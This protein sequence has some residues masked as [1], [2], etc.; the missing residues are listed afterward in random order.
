MANVPMT[1]IRLQMFKTTCA[2]LT[3]PNHRVCLQECI[4]EI[5]RVRLAELNTPIGM[6]AIPNSAELAIGYLLWLL[7]QEK[8]EFKNGKTALYWHLITVVGQHI[9]GGN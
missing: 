7:E 5:E 9:K 1:D 6:P 4:E 3:N 8:I 2:D